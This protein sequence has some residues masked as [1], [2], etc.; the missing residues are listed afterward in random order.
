MR[1]T[2]TFVKEKT[3]DPQEVKYT[4]ISD[5]TVRGKDFQVEYTIDNGVVRFGFEDNDEYLSILWRCGGK[6][7]A[8]AI[9]DA[10]KTLSSKNL[11]GRTVDGINTEL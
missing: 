7:L 11:S 6:P 8:K 2:I 3:E 9:Y 5:V 10:G 1:P 4:V